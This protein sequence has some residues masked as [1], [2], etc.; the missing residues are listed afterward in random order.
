VKRTIVVAALAA[1]AALVVVSPGEA[2]AP[3]IPGGSAIGSGLPLKAFASLDPP[4]QLFADPLTAK[5][6]IVADRKWVD[7]ANLRILVHFDPYQPT[8][9]PAVVRSGTG[10]IVEIT[11]T[12]TL[13]CLTAE[14]IPATRSSELSRIFR[15]TPATIEYRSRSGKVRYAFKAG[16]PP[17]EVSSQF[18]PKMVSLVEKREVARAWQFR[19]APVPAPHYRLAPSLA[20]WLAIA[21]ACVLGATGLAFAVRWALQFRSPAVAGAP[22]LPASP[23]ELA[24]TLFF[25]ARAHDDD[26]LQRKALERV[27]DELPLDV[28]EL[29]ETAHALA[30]SP[31]TPGEEDVQ[32]ISERAGL[33]RRNGEPEL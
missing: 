15:F 29:S 33:N 5:V 9:R 31:E 23:L 26:T 16:F 12:W 30:W 13:R 3:V 20:F 19:L 25:W 7:P 32:A 27:A 18:G 1:L 4:V 11:W 8:G 22:A 10:R 28:R 24:L 21:L 6:S 14:C 17:V 2:G